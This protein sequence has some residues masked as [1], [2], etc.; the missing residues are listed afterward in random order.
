MYNVR[1]FSF[2]I[3]WKYKINITLWYESKPSVQLSNVWNISRRR[4]WTRD[5]RNKTQFI[6]YN[7]KR[8]NIPKIL[9]FS[10]YNK[11]HITKY[12]SNLLNPFYKVVKLWNIG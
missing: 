10:K 11:Y 1:E 7:L 3:S 12:S 5:K 6:L 9:Y 2:K 4:I 8:V